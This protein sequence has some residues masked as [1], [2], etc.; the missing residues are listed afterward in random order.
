MGFPWPSKKGTGDMDLPQKT[1]PASEPPQAKAHPLEKAAELLGRANEQI[2]TYLIHESSKATGLNGEALRSLEKKLSLVA[3]TLERMES[4]MTGLPQGVPLSASSAGLATSALEELRDAV[5]QQGSMVSTALA[6]LQTQIQSEFQEMAR[7]VSPLGDRLQ[8]LA[9]R[10]SLPWEESASRSTPPSNTAW[11]RVILGP[12]LTATSALAVERQSLVDG[13]LRGD[14]GACSLGG[15]LLVFQSSPAERLPQLLKDI[16]EA[17]YHW[18]P[19]RRPG[20]TPLEE[21]LAQWLQR[22]C[23]EAGLA[24][25]IELVHP[26]ERFDVSR[27]HAVSR[28]VEITEVHGWIVLRDNGKVYTKAMVSVR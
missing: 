3:E 7:L 19:K 28:G 23:E 1:L 27:H 25:T 12:D 18:Q 9:G 2:A 11:E 5:Q 22:R 17:Y 16:G 21:A 24:N 8:V 20:T 15:Q 14:P 13:I 4:R 10:Q 26:G 6:Q